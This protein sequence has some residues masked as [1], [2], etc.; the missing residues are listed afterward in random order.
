MTGRPAFLR[1]GRH[2]RITRT[3]AKDPGRFRAER[4]PRRTAVPVLQLDGGEVRLSVA[5]AG[6]IQRKGYSTLNQIAVQHRPLDLLKAIRGFL[7]MPQILASLSLIAIFITAPLSVQGDIAKVFNPAVG[8]WHAPED[9]VLQGFPG[10]MDI[11]RYGDARVESMQCA[12]EPRDAPP[13]FPALGY[14]VA[15]AVID[16]P[17]MDLFHVHPLRFEYDKV[18]V[19]FGSGE[20]FDYLDPRAFEERPQSAEDPP[21]EQWFE[22]VAD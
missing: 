4:G 21:P 6:S 16:C 10:I 22:Y 8:V 2:S 13:P 11:S 12:W 14:T 20:L 7:L 19:V 9:A 15:M 3:P 17:G 5:T 1:H 18:S